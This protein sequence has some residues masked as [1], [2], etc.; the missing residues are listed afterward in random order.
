MLSA[1]DHKRR[2]D[3]ILVDSVRFS[4]RNATIAAAIARRVIPLLPEAEQKKAEARLAV[5]LK[6]KTA[7]KLLAALPA[8]ADGAIDWGLAYQ[9]VQ[10]LRS[11]GKMDEVW[12]ILTALPSDPDKLVSPDDWWMERRAAAYAALR[13]D[14]PDIAYADGARS[15]AVERQS[16]QGCDLHGRLAGTCGISTMPRPRWRISRHH[17]RPRTGH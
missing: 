6:A 3:R 13:A 5:F 2:L 7:D 9:R 11:L 12:K 14:K 16:A 8:E 1:D 4:A 15:R 17:E 10:H